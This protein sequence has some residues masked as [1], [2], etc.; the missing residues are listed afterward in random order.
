MP[1]GNTVWLTAR[2]LRAALAGEVLARAELRVPAHATV[3]LS[4]RRVVDVIP[5]AKHLLVRL[6]G[7]LTLHTHLRMDGAWRVYPAS[8]PVPEARDDVRVVLGTAERTAV[9]Y[10]VHDIAV[11]PTADEDSLVGHLGPDLLG[12]DWDAAEAVRRLATEPRRA[13]GEA[14]L[15]QRN[16]A[17]AGNVYKAEVCFLAGVSPWTAVGDVPDL[18]KFVDLLHRVLSANRERYSHVTTGDPRPGRQLWVFE[19]SRRPCRRC[20]TAIRSGWQGEPPYQRLSYWCPNC[21]PG[22]APQ[23]G[24]GG[25][26]TRSTRWPGSAAP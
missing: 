20:G 12:P 6:E 22:P 18:D 4:K 9:G 7:D 25:P 17:G 3:D 13:I 15:D 19:R 2:V 16:L 14:V 10:R 1:E 21:Q 23:P 11:V 26:A 24:A 8:R 5:R